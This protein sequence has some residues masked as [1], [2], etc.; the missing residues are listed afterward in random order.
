[1]IAKVILVFLVFYLVANAAYQIYKE[2]YW[3]ATVYAVLLIAVFKLLKDGESIL[4][5]NSKVIS[6]FCEI[7]S[8]FDWVIA[9]LIVFYIAIT[10][11]ITMSIRRN[12]F[13]VASKMYI[14]RGCFREVFT[15]LYF[16]LL[17]VKFCFVLYNQASSSLMGVISITGL[18]VH[19]FIGLV[20]YGDWRCV[21]HLSP[22][23][24]EMDNCTNF[25]LILFTI[26]F[27]VNTAMIIM[28]LL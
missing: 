7:A 6:V 2:M 18:I 28:A 16:I 12:C 10:V 21:Y 9:L 3:H 14:R 25:Q 17:V 4:Y 22:Y 23:Y 20:T 13:R 5:I 11:A 8:G 1:M 27:V 15:A 24:G 26:S 19:P